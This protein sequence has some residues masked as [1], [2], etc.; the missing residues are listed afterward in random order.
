M[1]QS[2]AWT[3]LDVLIPYSQ[4]TWWIISKDYTGVGYHFRNCILAV[5]PDS[6]M[7][8][9]FLHFSAASHIKFASTT[10]PSFLRIPST[11]RTNGENVS[12]YCGNVY[13]VYPYFLFPTDPGAFPLYPSSGNHSL[14]ST[15]MTSIMA[16]S[17]LYH[18][19]R[20]R[21][22]HLVSNCILLWCIYSSGM[23]WPWWM[24]GLPHT[25]W[26]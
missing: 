25:N 12:V 3:W 1:C 26:G 5:N 6:H 19:P 7:W 13:R 11:E 20:M 8:N 17:W 10:I 22:F 16:S 24:R 2:Q 14:G 18:N 23:M 9:G 4:V 15:S 21:K